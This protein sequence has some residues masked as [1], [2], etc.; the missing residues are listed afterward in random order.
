[1]PV[2]KKCRWFTTRFTRIENP[3]KAYKPKEENEEKMD[4]HVDNFSHDVTC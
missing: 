3:I 4:W 1:M 2:M